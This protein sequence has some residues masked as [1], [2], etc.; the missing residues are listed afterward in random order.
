MKLTFILLLAA[1][2]C[3]FAQDGGN[4]MFQSAG[5]AG[6]MAWGS[7]ATTGAAMNTCDASAGSRWTGSQY[8]RRT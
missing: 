4:V 6:A 1:S 8:D 5:P 3:A 2:F 7:G